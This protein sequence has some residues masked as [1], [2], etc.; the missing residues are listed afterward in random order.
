MIS[1]LSTAL[2][3]AGTK[4]CKGCTLEA[5]GVLVSGEAARVKDEVRECC[6][7]WLEE[8]WIDNSIPCYTSCPLVSPMVHC[9]R[10]RWKQ[11]YNGSVKL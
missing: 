3:D 6:E 7:G 4:D 5:V 9:W 10:R 11:A 8:A 2:V 1:Y